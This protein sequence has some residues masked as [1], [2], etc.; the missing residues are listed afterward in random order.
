MEPGLE[1]AELPLIT[2]YEKEGELG[3]ADIIVDRLAGQL[4][5]SSL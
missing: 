5:G 4:M 3:K 2:V 1:D